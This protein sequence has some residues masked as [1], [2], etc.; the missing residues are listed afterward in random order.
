MQA[1]GVL[2]VAAVF[3]LAAYA[4]HWLPPAIALVLLA[5][6]LAVAL[7]T[8]LLLR[9]SVAQESAAR[10]Q[11]EQRYTRLVEQAINGF[12][13]R[14]SEGQLLL[15]NEAY[16]R[17]T[18]YSREE[19]LKLKA[20]DMVV[21][22]TVLEK[23]ARLEPGQSTRIETLM[24]CKGGALRE[25]E[26]VTQRLP[27]GNLQSVLLD[28]SARKLAEKARQES[29]RRYIELVDQA[30]EGI[31]V[32]APEG[33]LLFVNDTLCRML[34]Y[35]R[36]EL[37]RL[38]MRD[39]V[40]PGDTGTVDRV[41]ELGPGRHLHLHKRMCR[42]DGRVVHVEVSARRLPDGNLQ[43]TVQDVSERMESE[44]RFRAMVEGAPNAMIMVDEGG[45]IVL[46]NPQAEKLFG[47]AVP[48]LVG[49]PV[50]MLVPLRYRRDHPAQREA[51]NAAPQMRAM[52]I[53]RDLY[54]VR[55]DGREVPV[56]I[57]LNPI[58]NSQGRFVLASIIDI[59]ERR[60]AEERERV[61][62]EE[63]RLMSQQLLEAQET[64]RRTI[65]R[66]LHDEVGQSLT[67]TRI[68][69]RDLEQDAAGGP[70]AQRLTDTAA[71]I[72]DLLQKVR[73]MSLDLHPSVLDDLGLVPALRWCVRTRTG[74]SGLEVAWDLPEDMPRF[75][76]MVE[77]TLFRV[78]QEAL[79]N[80]L[81]HAA[82][83]RMQVAVAHA[84][85]R[86]MLTVRDDGRGFDVD[87]ARRRAFAGASLGV[88]GMQERVR[89]AGGE[90]ALESSP[91]HGTEI[92]VSLPDGGR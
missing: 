87:A 78:F 28:V 35:S 55:K 31:L 10:L 9:R 88:L 89:L 91:G 79:S 42:K 56:E 1:A 54:G 18:G 82:A 22:Q 11:S 84:E 12:V 92:R 14:N 27:D 90:L 61:Y 74:G 5:S 64:E 73:Q 66:E 32:R 16:C 81:K 60:A 3:T 76:G 26:Y 48:E 33:Q 19:L 57:G 13:V 24:K 40:H 65:A 43:S 53:G 75:D 59:T 34:D 25:V 46:A 69:L 2:A 4:A 86:L 58:V 23:V 77:L 36:E 68:S 20:R 7:A 8:L 62:A 29:E 71:I 6:W 17:M 41:E 51:Y 39:I 45:A 30:L 67:A 15:V 63:L 72:A 83:R 38:N 85:G 50:E 49:K 52:G 47:Y 44:L 80:A 70:L 37:L 21:D